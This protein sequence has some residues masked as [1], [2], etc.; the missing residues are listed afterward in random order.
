[1]SSLSVV[2][3]GLHKP[4]ALNAELRNKQLRNMPLL[5]AG[6]FVLLYNL[7]CRHGVV[8]DLE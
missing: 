3:S 5:L 1:L 6:L 2:A 8:L 4:L 7:S